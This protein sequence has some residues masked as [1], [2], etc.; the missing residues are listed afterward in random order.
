MRP[1]TAPKRPKRKDRVRPFTEGAFI[2]TKRSPRSTAVI[3]PTTT[4]RE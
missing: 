2:S 1:Q 3:V 4:D